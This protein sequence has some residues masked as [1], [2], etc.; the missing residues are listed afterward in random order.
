MIREHDQVVLT[1]DLPEHALK[2]GDVGGVVPVY[3]EGEA[4]EVE[5]L[6]LAG[7]TTAVA[8]LKKDQ[9]RGIRKHEI[10]HVR[11]VLAA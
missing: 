3:P 6:T 1:E 2:A 11:E 7:E 4:C 9:A 10:P 8:T 5:F